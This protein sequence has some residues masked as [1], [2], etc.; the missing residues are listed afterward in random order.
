[1]VGDTLKSQ[2][3][4]AIVRS[5]NLTLAPSDI[6]DDVQLFGEGLGLDSVDALEFVLELER[7]FGVTI[8][9]EEVGQRVLRSVTSVAEFIEATRRAST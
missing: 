3:K 2:V 6:G 1:M 7:N 9:D 4:E 5:L 8:T